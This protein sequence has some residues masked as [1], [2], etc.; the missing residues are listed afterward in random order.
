[1]YVR[2]YDVCMMY[3]CVLYVLSIDARCVCGSFQ[4]RHSGRL[5][6]APTIDAEAVILT[7]HVCG[8]LQVLPNLTSFPWGRVSDARSRATRVTS[9]RKKRR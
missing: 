4:E 9:R 5:D 3:V 8:G 2:M 6:F 7:A 1:M